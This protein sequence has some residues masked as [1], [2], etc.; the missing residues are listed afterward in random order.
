[1][2]EF[3]ALRL[4]IRL[5]NGHRGAETILEIHAFACT[6]A[7]GRGTA[8]FS[9]PVAAML[10]AVHS[11]RGGSGD[12]HKEA[13]RRS[14]ARRLRAAL[15]ALL[16]HAPPAW[17]PLFPTW[18]SASASVATTTTAK[19]AAAGAGASG[20]AALFPQSLAALRGLLG[21]HEPAVSAAAAEEQPPRLRARGARTVKMPVR[22]D[23][24]S[25]LPLVAAALVCRFLGLR[26]VRVWGVDGFF[27]NP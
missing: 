24:V 27:L 4:I 25:A 16:S 3:N 10:L 9:P 19:A 21:V 18:A 7:E 15:Q 22:I 11:L 8:A 12:G 23:P 14:T 13:E 5:T 2:N 20:S 6:A 17:R 26:C 1:V